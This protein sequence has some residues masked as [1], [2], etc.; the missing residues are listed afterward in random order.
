MTKNNRYT[1]HLDTYEMLEDILKI[2]KLTGK[3][4]VWG[5]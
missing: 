5:F 1:K 3:G 4:W 2:R